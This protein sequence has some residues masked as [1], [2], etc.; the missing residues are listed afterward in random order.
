MHWS[1]ITAVVLVGALV[2]LVAYDLFAYAAGGNEATISRLCLDTANR[3]RA[4][5]MI[6]GFVAG[7]L[8]GHLFLP[9]HEGE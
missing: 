1:V 7:V 8:F 4:L 2:L 9:Q 6:A 3:Y 5:A